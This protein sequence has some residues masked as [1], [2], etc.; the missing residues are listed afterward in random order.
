MPEMVYTYI[1]LSF[2]TLFHH[3]QINVDKTIN[4][5]NIYSTL[6]IRS[7]VCET[8]SFKF[9]GPRNDLNYCADC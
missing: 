4:L 1:L 9:N 8:L 2:I 6:N 7:V 5:S 3:R